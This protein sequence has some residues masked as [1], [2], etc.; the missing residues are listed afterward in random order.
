MLIGLF[1]EYGYAKMV[2]CQERTL[3]ESFDTADIV[4]TGKVIKV[5][6]DEG[7]PLKEERQED[8]SV[9]VSLSENFWSKKAGQ[10]HHV[11]VQKVY[12][13]KNNKHVIIYSSEVY[14]NKNDEYLI[15]ANFNNGRFE[16]G[17]CGKVFLV[18]NAS[19]EMKELKEYSAQPG[20]NGK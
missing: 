15:F 6:R 17:I 3:Q 18:S 13:G 5:V 19:H 4:L 2:L 20:P 11:K 16:V 10:S 9:Q 7:I 14:L 1:Q 12:K 8:G